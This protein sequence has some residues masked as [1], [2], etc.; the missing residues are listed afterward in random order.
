MIFAR[1]E[2]QLSGRESLLS[3][4][5]VSLLTRQ[6][7]RFMDAQ[8]GMRKIPILMY[9][10]I[11]EHATTKY[12]PLAVP[13]ALFAEHMA[14]LSQ[15]H[16]VPI[17]VTQF[18]HF[19]AGNVP[20]PERPVILTFDDGFGDF[21]TGAFP[22]LQKYGFTATLYVATAFVNSTSRWLENE[23][24][25]MRPML[26]WKQLAQISAAGIECGG[27][28]HRHPQL[29]TLPLSIARN[30]ITLCKHL[31]EQRLSCE[32][33]SF[34]YPYGYHS[35]AIKQLVR[36]AGYTSA[37]AVKYEMCS[38][39]TDPYALPRLMMKADTGTDALGALLSTD[40]PSIF[41]RAYK[42]SRIPVWRLVRRCL[43][44]IRLHHREELQ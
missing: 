27:H 25:G 15:H 17:T 39:T 28:T 14:Y 9:H 3:N 26:T 31:L 41:T 6:G 37:C 32:V 10:S 33:A 22:A 4:E 29:D 2:L 19:R 5:S 35:S 34:A 16:Y 44:S 43:A 7:K 8:A 24:E 20:L 36:E 30:E 11:S 23:G 13:P 40:Y 21:F 1:K 42:H 12:R 18:I 38:A